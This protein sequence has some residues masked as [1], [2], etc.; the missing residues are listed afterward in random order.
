MFKKIKDYFTQNKEYKSAKKTITLAIMNQYYDFLV[1]ETEA[2][3][4]EKKAYESMTVFGD[5]FK[6]EDFQ[7]VMNS[8]NKIAG[9]P[10]LTSQFYSHIADIASEEKNDGLKVVK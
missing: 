5:N 9:S 6:V 10:E 8:I 4:A 1:A 3:E 2:K 7:S